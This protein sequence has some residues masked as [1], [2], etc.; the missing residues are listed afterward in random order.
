MSSTNRGFALALQH[1]RT[2]PFFVGYKLAQLRDQQGI[3]PEQQAAD[4]GIDL[5]SLAFL[6]LCKMPQTPDDVEALAQ[7]AG[8]ETARLAQV[9]AARPPD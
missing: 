6:C 1:T 8:M 4:L 2:D 5:E 7:K 3:G 9:L